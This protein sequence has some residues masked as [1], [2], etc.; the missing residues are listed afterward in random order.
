M[1]SF[2]HCFAHTNHYLDTA[3]YGLP[4][5]TAH[6][7]ALAAEHDRAAGRLDLAA[8]DRAVDRSRAAFARLLGVPVHRVAI[9]SQVAPAVG[10][11]A[12]GLR[13]GTRV[14]LAEGDF[15]SLLFPFLVAAERGVSARAVPL[16]RLA[17][18][19]EDGTDLVAVSA[20]QSADGS[21]APLGRIL[22]AAAAHGARVLVDA[23]Q[24]AGWLPLPVDRI[25]L[26]VCGGY[27]WLLG[28]RG[29]AFLTGTEEAL[30]EVPA[31]GA[32]WY[33]GKDVWGSI[34]GTPLRLATD[35]R[36]LDTPPAW[37]SWAGQ[38]PALEF[39]DD[40]GVPRVHA[41]DLALA[42]RFRAGLGLPPGDSAIVSL[43]VPD[44]TAARLA[45]HGVVAS[46][47]GGRLRCSFHLST[48]RDDVDRTLDLLTS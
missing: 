8:T 4:P 39:L 19:V 25:D 10:M 31:V 21:L 43:D 17:D 33:A 36:R 32:N 29:T 35:A 12:A 30:A 48:T 11:I 14:L 18:A 41:H 15:T 23:T 5:T 22:D 26:L 24:A 3:T 2:T 1:E 34:Y 6:R 46:V 13:P 47:R 28:P 9:G 37:A 44:G 20:V 7:A 38:A 45:A 42:N 16:D 27:K 40:I